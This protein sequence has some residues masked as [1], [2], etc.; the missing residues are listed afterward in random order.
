MALPLTLRLCLRALAAV[1]L[2]VPARL[3]SDW[4]REW[5][6]ELHHHAGSL[7]THPSAT[8]TLGRLAIR[9]SGAVADALWLRQQSI[10]DLE[11][12]QDVRYGARV[13]RERPAFTIFVAAVLALGIGATT[14]IF[15]VVDAVLLQRPPYPEPGRLVTVWETELISGRR[16]QVAPA[17]F[18]DWR[19]RSR[20]FEA[21]AAIEPWSFDRT[22]GDEPEMLPASLV[23]EGFFE[24]LGVQPA[25]GRTFTD[26]EHQEGRDRV[27]ILTD[28]SWRR[29]FSADPAVIGRSVTLDDLPYTVVGLLPPDFLIR[30]DPMETTSEA[31]APKVFG[32]QD[33]RTRGGGWWE[34]VA[35]VQPDVTRQQAQA[36]MDTIAAQ[37]AEEHPRINDGVGAAIVP[38]HDQQIG[39][40]RLPLIVLLGAVGLVLLIACGN[41]AN[42]LLARC[43]QRQPEFAVRA[44]LGAGRARLIRQLLTESL[45]IALIG[46]AGGALLAYWLTDLIVALGPAN[47]PRI[48]Q[49]GLHLRV[50]AFGLGLSILTALVFGT[51][52]ATHIW[53]IDLQGS[54]RDGRP[55]VSGG[56]VRQ[57]LRGGLVIGQIALALVLLIGAGLLLRSFVTLVSVDPG[58]ERENTLAL[59][60]FAWDRNT[61]AARRSAFFQETLDRIDEL[62]GVQAAG[63]VSSFPFGPADLTIES[64]FFVEGRPRPPD[65][66][67]PQIAV[68]IATPAYF[69]A[70]GIP[71]RRGRLFSDRDTA[72]T[73]PVALVTDTVA[74]RYWPGDN[75]I[76]RRVTVR[77]LGDTIT[78]EVVGI[79]GQVCHRG[80]DREPRPEVFL[81]HAQAPFGS[82]TYVVRG[83]GDA[84]VLTQAVKDAVW[85]VDKLQ[86]FYSVSTLDNLVSQTVAGRRF[87]LLLLGV[88]A[89]L[90]LILAAVGIYGVIHFSTTQR[91]HELGMRVA[92]GARG[93][94]IVR[95]VIRQAAALT[96][97]GLAVGL[98]GAFGLTR[99][100]DSLLFE[101]SPTDPVTLVGVCLLLAAVALTACYLPALRAS[102]T[103]PAVALRCE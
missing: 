39:N 65:G 96:M 51:A 97:T 59:Q 37:L 55:A 69:R 31:F 50:L 52:P 71:L 99:F 38:L 42:L 77:W 67:E 84:A 48:D 45:V 15:S 27:V 86:A 81:P 47:I 43:V 79:V 90:A 23:S 13:L 91:S 46:G 75:P 41:V 44:A 68:S 16:Q 76:R 12:F 36:E 29:R 78:A 2:L 34:V 11:L 58:F 101:V 3:R 21:I 103:D 62:P 57:R 102:R 9:A 66:E 70:M 54:L 94:D 80:L 93:V 88:L 49:A 25:L 98:V 22:D 92:L 17:N 95:L 7:A 30:L 85:S 63:A 24:L 32:E 60:V 1:R 87:S 14:A 73:S 5:E 89:M 56:S 33:R 18:L 82:M 100:L 20:A 26:T 19:E 53:R 72:D 61:T 35:R 4:Y 10:A 64:P 74:R 83:T 8:F 28:A 6:A 40:A